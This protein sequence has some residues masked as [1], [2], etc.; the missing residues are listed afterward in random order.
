MSNP[1]IISHDEDGNEI[2]LNGK[3]EVCHTCSG[4]GK[5]VNPSIDGNGISRDQFDEDPDFAEAYFRGDY[6]VTC[7]TCE[8]KR[9]EVVIDEENN[10]KELIDAYYRE[11][12]EKYEY[13][14]EQY[15]E[16]RAEGQEVYMS[17]FGY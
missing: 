4:S 9:V 16:M 8:G 15:A 1:K 7:R 11:E 10:S 2:T 17:D 6:D 3:Y 12:Q 5:T 14:R 13:A